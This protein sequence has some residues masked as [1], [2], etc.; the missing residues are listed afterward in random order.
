MTCARPNRAQFTL[1]GLDATL[2]EGPDGASAR[3][4]LNLN[5]LFEGANL[6][7]NTPDTPPGCMGRPNE[8]I[9]CAPIYQSLNLDFTSGEPIACDEGAC[10]A[11]FMLY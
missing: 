3:V 7:A 6:N 11:P 5:T 8:M 10:A 1:S 2:N 9:E 4:H